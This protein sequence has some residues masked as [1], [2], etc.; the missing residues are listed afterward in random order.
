MSKKSVELLPIY[1]GVSMRVYYI[2]NPCPHSGQE[3]SSWILPSAT[4]NPP[5]SKSIEDPV[6]VKKA[7]RMLTQRNTGQFRR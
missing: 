4:K 2:H 6:H 7:L 5:V 3:L 1:M